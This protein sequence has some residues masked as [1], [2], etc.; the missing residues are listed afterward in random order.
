MQKFNSMVNMKQRISK[1]F[2]KHPP[3]A[4]NEKVPCVSKTFEHINQKN[5]KPK[6]GLNFLSKT[7]LFHSYLNT[8][9]SHCKYTTEAGDYIPLS[10]FRST[11][12]SDRV[13][14]IMPVSIET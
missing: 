13:D 12:P 10:I 5:V 14:L 1:Q 7:D 2:R 3:I 8:S 11:L 4:D 6:I 9:I